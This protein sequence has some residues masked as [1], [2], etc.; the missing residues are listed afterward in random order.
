MRVLDV[1]CG[2]GR[3]A[4]ALA[5]RGVVVHG[6]DVSRRF[7]DLA[8]ERAPAG[9]TFERLD[10]R[11][12][13][14]DGEFDAVDLPVPGCVRPDDGRWTRRDGDRRDVASAA[15]RR[16]PG[17]ERLQ[18]LFRAE[19]LGGAE[20]DAATGVNH[21]R[22]E[23]RDEAGRASRRVCGPAATRRGSCRLLCAAHGLAVD[24]ISSVEP[25][26]YGHRRRPSTPRVPAAGDEE[27]LSAGPVGT[28]GTLVAWFAALGTSASAHYLSI[29]KQS[30]LCPIPR[31][32]PPKR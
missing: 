23:I 19:A 22:T 6:V 32:S 25:G 4:H 11:H 3:H 20:F 27:P 13:A 28:A 21:E 8:T 31:P 2:P 15:T 29:R 5:E 14:F 1:G 9:A 16:P 7:V 18:R 26:A 24:S 30:V 12:M 10:A 17:A